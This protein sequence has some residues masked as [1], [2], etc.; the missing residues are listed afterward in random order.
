[1]LS[2]ITNFEALTVCKPIYGLQQHYRPGPY[3]G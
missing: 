2:T 1:M 3:Q